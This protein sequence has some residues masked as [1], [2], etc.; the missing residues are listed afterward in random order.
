MSKAIPILYIMSKI[1]GLDLPN[2]LF[3]IDTDEEPYILTVG[4]NIYILSIKKESKEKSFHVYN[5]KTRELIKLASVVIESDDTYNL[6]EANGKIYVLIDDHQLISYDIETNVWDTKPLKLSFKHNDYC[7]MISSN[8]KIVVLDQDPSKS[9]S[10]DL[11]THKMTELKGQP[12]SVKSVTDF[13]VDHK[14][15][16]FLGGKNKRTANHIYD[17][18]V[19]N[20]VWTQVPYKLPGHSMFGGIISNDTFYVWHDV[21]GV[22]DFYS[23]SDGWKKIDRIKYLYV[24]DYITIVALDSKFL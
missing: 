7:T 16:R 9:E 24:F 13:K 5:F 18:D 15:Y 21:G 10:L 12:I 6:A 17:Y 8:D 14:T 19:D 4:P 23:F 3:E 11:K 22:V 2:T 1:K 20:D